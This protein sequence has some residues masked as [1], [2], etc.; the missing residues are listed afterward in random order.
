VGGV[1]AAKR[2]RAGERLDVVI[3]AANVIDQLVSEGRALPGSRVDLVRS[4]VAIAVQAGAPRPDIGSENAVREAVRRASSVSYS[5]GPSGDYLAKLF[6]RWGIADEIAGRIV[7]PPP[8]IPVGRLVAEGSVELG[9][10]QLS[11][12]MFLPGIAVVGPLPPAIQHVTTFSAG[13]CATTSRAD[14]AR[15]LLAFMAS[16]ATAEAKRRQ[17]MEPA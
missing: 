12:L 10:Q 5:T 17:G 11:E 9:F 4:G 14:E 3:L 1:D 16:P 2:V 7:K 15:R 8:G 6:E 13:I